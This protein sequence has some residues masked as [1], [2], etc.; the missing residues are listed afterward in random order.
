MFAALMGFTAVRQADIAATKVAVA[1]PKASA[2]VPTISV[3]QALPVVAEKA[4][5]MWATFAVDPRSSVNQLSSAVRVGWLTAVL[6]KPQPAAAPRTI[7]KQVGHASAA[8]N[9]ETPNEIILSYIGK[10]RISHANRN[11]RLAGCK[12]SPCAKLFSYYE[13]GKK[14][15]WSCGEFPFATSH[16]GGTDSAIMCVPQ[17]DNSVLGNRWGQSV[18]GKKPGTK[19]QRGIR[20]GCFCAVLGKSTDGIFVDGSVY[21]N[22][23]DGKVAMII[24][25]DIPIDFEGS[26]TVNYTVAS[27]S[28]K[29]GYITDDWGEDYGALDI[30]GS[31]K[32]G[33]NTIDIGPDGVGNAMIMAWVDDTEVKLDYTTTSTATTSAP[34][35]TVVPA[36]TNTDSPSLGPSFTEPPPSIDIG[37]LFVTAGAALVTR[38]HADR[39]ALWVP[40]TEHLEDL[41]GWLDGFWG[42]HGEGGE[43][44][45]GDGGENGGLHDDAWDIGYGYC[46]SA[47]EALREC[48]YETGRRVR[49]VKKGIN[50]TDH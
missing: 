30:S 39:V 1:L 12:G 48:E 16:E 10:N 4:V 6:P 13:N 14:V 18:R 3:P 17:S 15:K 44:Q 21:G 31:A 35:S 36:T 26:Y 19:P 46:R 23:S 7:A 40:L 20:A 43:S 50:R 28:I 8:Y 45:K 33:S 34:T 2:A 32:S 29:S 25:L 9:P 41:S 47:V 22:S 49:N 27:G 11:R 42:C 38:V 24:P 5:Q 37:H